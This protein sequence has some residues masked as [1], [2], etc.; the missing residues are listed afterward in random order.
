MNLKIENYIENFANALLMTISAKDNYTQM[1]SI[2]VSKLAELF[3]KKIGLEKSTL[4][5]LRLAGIFHDIG[6]I[7]IPDSVLTKQ[8]KLTSSEYNTMKLHPVIGANILRTS[9]IYEDIADII[10]SHHERPDGLGYP[11]G[12]KKDQIPYLSMILAMCD[13]FD[14]MMC[15]RAYK[16]EYSLEYVKSELEKGRDKQFDNDLVT[17]FLNIIENDFDEIDKILKEA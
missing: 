2:R 7:G 10:V 3:G 11:N 14:A 9:Q 4:K 6:K 16:N 1:H 17:I 12:L 15:K 5:N 8:D 13:S